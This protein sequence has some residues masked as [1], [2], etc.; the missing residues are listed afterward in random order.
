MDRDEL[1]DRVRKCSK[2]LGDPVRVAG[3]RVAGRDCGDP[4]AVLAGA[5]RLRCRLFPRFHERVPQ[6]LFNIDNADYIRAEPVEF[7]DVFVLE[8]LV[9]ERLEARVGNDYR[10]VEAADQVSISLLQK[11]LNDL[12][13]GIR[14][15][16][17]QGK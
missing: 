7:G 4:L 11:R 9:K 2:R 6:V 16:M 1:A 8:G 17:E 12:D 5:V 10:G 3:R 14:I 13:T 15:S